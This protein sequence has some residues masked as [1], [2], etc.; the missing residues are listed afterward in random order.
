MGADVDALLDGAQTASDVCQ[1]DHPGD[2]NSGLWLG[3]TLG[4]LALRG[5]DKLTFVVDDPEIET[6]GL[7]LEQLI[8]ESTGKQGKGILPVAGEPLGDHEVYGD[9]RVFVH[10]RGEK[11]K[12]DKQVGLLADHGHAVL[13]IHT[14]GAT[15]LG[16]I[17]F[18]AEFATA[19][20]GWALQINPFD[21]P[22]VQ[23]AK[24]N[25]KRVIDEGAPEIPTGSLDDVLSGAEPPKYVA[26][27]AYVPPSDE[28]DRQAGELRERIRDDTKCTTTFGYGPRY[29]HS[30]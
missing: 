15:D 19:V 6:I 26:I 25:T 29:L 24:D 17:F 11:P 1:P 22:N 30:T 7:W 18:F 8:A 28:T 9:D 4:E 14:K 21:Q 20:A 12:L 5:R 10:L 13:T 2:H 16:R 3:A 27:L 23:E